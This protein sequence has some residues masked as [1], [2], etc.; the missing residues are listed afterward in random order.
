MNHE[1]PDLHDNSNF[2]NQVL[3]ERILQQFIVDIAN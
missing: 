3:E 1:E 2:S